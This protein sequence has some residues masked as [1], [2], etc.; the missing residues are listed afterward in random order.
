MRKL[1]ESEVAFQWTPECQA[2]WDAVIEAVTQSRGLYHP[3]WTKPFFLRTDA[4]KDGLGAYLF[5][6]HEYVDDKGKRQSEERVISYWSR[7]VPKACRQYDTRRLELMAVILALEHFRLFI[8]GHPTTLET[9]HRNLTFLINNRHSSGQ[10][11]R[12]AMRLEQFTSALKMTFRPGKDN[13]VAD[14]LSRNPQPREAELED[15]PDL[16]PSILQAYLL[17]REIEK[18]SDSPLA[19]DEIVRFPEPLH[20]VGTALFALT[21]TYVSPPGKAGNVMA[22]SARSS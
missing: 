22:V 19:K 14:C 6:M 18:R 5:Y 15:D 16:H 21:P 8:E 10:L 12:W 4:S 3:D 17:V 11:A 1:T 9:D 2:A 7:S 20:S 13:P